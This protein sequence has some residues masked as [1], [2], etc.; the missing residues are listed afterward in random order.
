MWSEPVECPDP[1]EAAA[2]LRAL[3]GLAFLDS[4]VP[5]GANGRMSILA[6]APCAEFTADGHGARFAGKPLAGAPFEA[7]DALLARYRLAPEP[8]WPSFAGGFLGVIDY[9]A[10]HWAEPRTQAPGFDPTRTLVSLGLYDTALV[11]DHTDGS[12]R[13]VATG[14]SATLDAASPRSDRRDRAQERLALFREALARPAP[15]HAP[16]VT[17][18]PD[19]RS[20]RDEP[21]YAAMVE[22]V[23]EAILRG[24]IFQANVSREIAAPCPPGLDPFAFYRRLRTE[25]PAPYAAYLERPG[26]TIASSSPELF[27]RLRGRAVE[28]RPIKG[29]LRRSAD[30]R[31]DEALGRALAVSEKDRAENVMIV[32]LSRNDLSRVCEGDSIEVPTLCGL[33]S[34][35]G[36]HHLVSVVTGRLKADLGPGALVAATFPGGSITGAPKIEAMM[37]IAREE[38]RLRGLYCGSVAAFSATGNADLSIAIRTVTFEAGTV[39]F[40]AGGGVTV[41]SEGA[42]EYRE[43]Q[44]KAERILAAF[45]PPVPAGR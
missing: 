42:A 14:F 34:F 17:P 8:G 21:A 13:L 29:T 9:E 5:G 27:L 16:Q 3:G 39:R 11:L 38:G 2:R 44:T 32:D 31:E 4:A 40:A 15:A 43:T 12:A 35:A 20:D 30:P 45:R 33:E 41:L 1:I 6:A 28:T 36:V 19:W 23:R 24:D 22:R 25:N 10:G 18:E 26:C 37:V 7:L